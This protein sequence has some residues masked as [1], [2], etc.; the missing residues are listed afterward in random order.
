MEGNKSHEKTVQTE[1]NMNRR[2]PNAHEPNVMFRDVVR[3][4]KNQF[5]SL[6]SKNPLGEGMLLGI[7]PVP[8]KTCKSRLL[9][10]TG[11]RSVETGR[12]S[13]NSITKGVEARGRNTKGGSAGGQGG[14]QSELT[15]F[16][17]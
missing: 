1:P 12:E 8:P 10:S 17:K 9:F 16:R 3:E 5:Q 6:P 11:S 13:C 4:I 2:F 7:Y 15:L 14:H